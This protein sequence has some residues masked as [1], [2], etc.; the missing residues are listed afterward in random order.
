M[1]TEDTY[2]GDDLGRTS[3]QRHPGNDNSHLMDSLRESS[4]PLEANDNAVADV[5]P[6]EIAEIRAAE[7]E[8]AMA[9]AHANGENY[10]DGTRMMDGE[11]VE[12]WITPEGSTVF[13]DR[14]DDQIVEVR[15]EDDEARDAAIDAAHDAG[16]AFYVGMTEVDG[17]EV[18]EWIAPDGSTVYADPDTG[19]VV[20]IRWPEGQAPVYMGQVQYDGQSAAVYELPNGT[21]VVVVDGET[22]G[23]LDD[24]E[25]D[26][27]DHPYWGDVYIVPTGPPS[28]ESAV[29][30]ADTGQL[31]E[32]YDSG[33]TML[34]GALTHYQPPGEDYVVVIDQF[35]NVIGT[36]EV[37][38][39]EEWSILGVTMYEDGTVTIDLGGGELTVDLDSDGGIWFTSDGLGELIEGADWVGSVEAGVE[40]NEEGVEVDV[41][42]SVAG[43]GELGYGFEVGTDGFD[44]YAEV[45]M[46]IEVGGM[47][48]GVE[49]RGD[50][51]MT[52]DGTLYGGADV[53]VSGTVPGGPSF[54]ASVD[55][56]LEIGPDGFEAEAGWDGTVGMFGAYLSGGDQMSIDYD[57]DGLTVTRDSYRGVGIEG[58]GSLRVG[59]EMQFH[60]DGTKGGTE[61]TGGLYGATANADHE[62]TGRS[63]AYM[64]VDGDGDVSTFTQKDGLDTGVT[65]E[66]YERGEG[67]GPDVGPPDGTADFEM[68]LPGQEPPGEA[69]E[70]ETGGEDGGGGRPGPAVAADVVADVVADT[71]PRAPRDPFDEIVDDTGAERGPDLPAG[72]DGR[73][74][75][76]A[77]APAHQLAD[78]LTTPGVVMSGGSTMARDERPGRR[79]DT[80]APD[81]GAERQTADLPLDGGEDGVYIEETSTLPLRPADD[82]LV[83]GDGN[84]M[85]GVTSTPPIGHSPDA[86]TTDPVV[87]HLEES[88]I[89][90]APMG[91]RDDDR[92]FDRLDDRDHLDDEGM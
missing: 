58:V 33:S 49:A 1:P 68:D 48:L 72:D 23:L 67:D 29:Y 14:D 9:E 40:W 60:T 61:V 42:A 59:G 88:M 55:G 44:M 52:S 83:L 74:D 84:T 80:D 31:L 25:L 92:P 27:T 62:E 63:G 10:Y 87:D 73:P 85:P 71:G 38:P 86:G 69:P 12:V 75:D 26:T 11:E 8:A 79:P 37:P 20:A 36:F 65:R 54:T 50:F 15:W 2:S 28:Y 57:S 91:R 35:G 30:D 46:G 90:A 19:E 89:D 13:Y 47:D 7:R 78:D 70:D 41:S 56:Y 43:V 32:G 17:Q 16:D 45:D 76:L 66:D 39:D 5:D 24:I 34:D 4:P 77:P 81:A 51:G 18:Q 22:V 6:E 64:S 3:T 53:S 82:S 21:K